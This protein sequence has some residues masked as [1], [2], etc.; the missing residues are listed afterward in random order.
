[1]ICQDVNAELQCHSKH[2][3]QHYVIPLVPEFFFS[4]RSVRFYC[5]PS[6]VLTVNRDCFVFLVSLA[7][8]AD[9]AAVIKANYQKSTCLEYKISSWM[10]KNHI[11]YFWNQSEGFLV[12]EE[13][14]NH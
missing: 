5:Y 9:E 3:A 4:L 14:E 12:A 7:L 6:N 2:F 8:L 11:L 13:A 10:E 1:M